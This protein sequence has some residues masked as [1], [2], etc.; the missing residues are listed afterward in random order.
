[1]TNNLRLNIL[2]GEEISS[3]YDKCV[4]FLS[5]KGV[6]IDYP[7]ALKI[8]DKA[9]AYV[10]F[11]TRQIRFPRDIIEAA[12]QS[13]PRSMT[14]EGGNKRHD[15]ILPHPK[16]LFYTL[17]NTGSR[18]YVEPGSNTY[19]D[20]ILADVAEYG[21]LTEALGDIDFSSYINP[22]D[23]PEETADIHALKTLFESTSKHIIGQIYSFESIEYLIELAM[24]VAG[25][26]GDSKKRSVMSFRTG[27]NT[28][29]VLSAREAEGIIQSC[30]HEMPIMAQCLPSAGAT[31]P[32]TIAGTVL[33]AGVEIL[34]TLIMSQIIRPGHP[35][36]GGGSTYTLD[37]ATGRADT[38]SIES[39]LASAAL[40]QFVKDAFHIPTYTLGFGTDSYIPDGEAMMGTTLRGLFTS[41]A[42]ADI[43]IA[44]GRLNSAKAISPIELILDNTLARILKRAVAGV[45]VDDNTLA[46]EEIMETMPGGHFLEQAHTLQHCREGLRTELFISRPYETWKAEHSK[47]LHAR[48]VE[49]YRKMKKELNP[50][51]LHEGVQ[52]ELNRIVK[53]ADDHLVK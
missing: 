9:G 45:S 47:D 4:D 11:D 3:I 12:L 49:K 16:G 26:T 5:N 34:V 18:S 21:Q 2:S 53:H 19:R 6:K 42:N 37:M 24:V 13:V 15:A 50:L 31:S 44:A 1:M 35:L 7:E 33:V 20:V 30:R 8:L 40:V 46:W 38:S 39:I 14:L 10:D 32:I 41:L 27:F 22:S 23:V 36:S 48:A 17:N 28:P 43:L 52:K 51:G 25:N 29:F